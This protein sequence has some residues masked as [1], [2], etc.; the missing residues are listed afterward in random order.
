MTICNES[1]LENHKLFKSMAV[2]PLGNEFNADYLLE[3]IS[4]KKTVIKGALL[5]QRIVVGLGNI[6]VCEALNMAKISPV[7]IAYELSNDEAE[8]L[9]PIIR[10]IL[11]R[12]I[13]AGGASLKDFAGVEGDLGYFQHQFSAYGREGEACKNDG[14]KGIIDRIIQGGRST[15]YCPICQK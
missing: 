6:Y 14:C 5:D 4:G 1:E 10:E 9:V 2:E 8:K 3:K 11:T 15:F 7:R 12:A 13:E